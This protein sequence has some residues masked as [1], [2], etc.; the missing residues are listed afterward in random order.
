MES[1]IPSLLAVFA[2]LLGAVTAFRAAD[3]S[4]GRISDSWKDMAHLSDE[5][6][7][8]RLDQVSVQVAPD[9]LTVSLTLENT[10]QSML[11]A[12]E[13][14]DVIVEYTAVGGGRKIEPLAF[15]PGIPVAGQ[16]TVWSI[17]PD[18]VDPGFLDPGERMLL[19]LRLSSEILAGAVS[20]L[21]VVAPNGATTTV[22]FTR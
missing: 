21:V 20:R 2:L 4:V 6:V 5:R 1:A 14:T 17:Q 8:T 15:V 22:Q 11:T 7:R 13:R 16:W 9:G 3:D 18:M 12:F 10:G 19:S